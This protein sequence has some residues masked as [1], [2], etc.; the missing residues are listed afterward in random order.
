MDEYILGVMKLGGL[1][2]MRA[3]DTVQRQG[4]MN[5]LTSSHLM[6]ML[7]VRDTN[8]ISVV[9]GYAMQ[10]LSA[11]TLGAQAAGYQLADRVP[12]PK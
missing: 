12:V 5:L 4:V 2:A 6:N 7:F 8:E 11:S 3:D 9:E 10:G 1:A